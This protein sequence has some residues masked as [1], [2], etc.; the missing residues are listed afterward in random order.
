MGI[1]NNFFKS[2]EGSESNSNCNWIPLTSNSQIEEIQAL[3]SES[4]IV[5]FKHSTRCSISSVVL[6]RFEKECNF[7]SNDAVKLYL[8]DLLSFRTLSNSIAQVFNI[9]HQSPQL[10]V[11]KNNTVVY[12]ASHF[13]IS[14]D[15]V[16]T[17]LSQ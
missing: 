9:P 17:I 8:L 6:S 10:I 7:T 11:I 15:K 2:N 14:I 13:S 4:T 5:I 12:S 16:K 1:F 3:S